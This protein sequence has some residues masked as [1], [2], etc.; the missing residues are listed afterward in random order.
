MFPVVHY[1]DIAGAL[2]EVLNGKVELAIL[3]ALSLFGKES[4]LADERLEIK[5]VIDDNSYYGVV[6]AGEAERLGYCINAYVTSNHEDIVNKVGWEYFKISSVSVLECCTVLACAIINW[7][8][9]LSISYLH[10]IWLGH[11]SNA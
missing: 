6:V 9:V 10:C 1:A 8:M 4:L 7:Q 11:V 3:D 2:Q 5:S